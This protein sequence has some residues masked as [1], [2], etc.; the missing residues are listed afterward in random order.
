MKIKIFKFR[1]KDDFCF[2]TR[3]IMLLY[4]VFFLSQHILSQNG[5]YELVGIG[6]TSQII[7]STVTNRNL[8]VSIE[9]SRAFTIKMRIYF[10]CSIFYI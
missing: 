9:I 5:R 4:F 8:T 1:F 7:G 3:I 10:T 2:L 6:G